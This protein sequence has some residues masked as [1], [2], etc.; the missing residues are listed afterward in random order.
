MYGLS[1]IAMIFFL[2]NLMSIEAQVMSRENKI[3]NIPKVSDSNKIPMHELASWIQSYATTHTI[4]II[5]W[6]K[7]N[8]Q[9]NVIFQIAHTDDSILLV[10]HVTEKHVLAKKIKTN[11]RTHQD[12][13]VEFFISIENNQNYY[14]FEFNSIGTALIAYGSNLNPREFISPHLIKKYVHVH[15]SL[16]EDPLDIKK[17]DTSWVLSIEIDK[18]IFIHHPD[19]KLQDLI[20]RGNFYKCGDLTIEPHFLSWNQVPT[21]SPSFHQPNYFGTLVFQ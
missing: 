14:N 17:E 7:F 2:G 4:D 11:T 10:Y 15:S 3:L 8:Y 21:K 1:Q 18:R 13:C 6:P 16:G 5:N 19:L 12:S 9:P 20:A